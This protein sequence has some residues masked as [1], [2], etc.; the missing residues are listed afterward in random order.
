MSDDSNNLKKITILDRLRSLFASGRGIQEGKKFTLD[1][2]PL[3]QEYSDIELM[4]L[5]N[6]EEKMKKA[7]IENQ[8]NGKLVNGITKD[9]A[10]KMLQWVVQAARNVLKEYV[11][12]SFKDESLL[13]WCG[14]GQALTGTTLQ[15]LGL[16]PNILN[17]NPHIGADTG[18]H[19]FLTVEMPIVQENGEVKN[20]PYLVDTTFRQFFLRNEVTTSQGTFIKDKR[21]G[22]RVAPLAGYWLLQ[23]PGGEKLAEQLLSKGFIEL[24]EDSAKLYGDAFVLEETRRKNP[25]QVPKEK[26]LKTGISGKLY[27]KNLTHPLEQEKIDFDE[28]ELAPEKEKMKTPMRIRK[29]RN[30]VRAP[31]NGI[32]EQQN[33]NDKLKTETE[34]LNR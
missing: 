2:E 32:V 31:I 16:E 20:Y 19:A 27:L 22:N 5:A 12:D 3:M 25:T 21:F 34:E 11:S 4:N 6:I 26:E 30:S 15:E 28:E 29:E 13:G 9:E 14:F 33:E 10:E 7:L 8:I 17:A 23:M 24:N 1:T 18:R